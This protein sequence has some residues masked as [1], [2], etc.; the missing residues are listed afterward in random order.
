MYELDL[1]H[2]RVKIIIRLNIRRMIRKNIKKKK[3][4]MKIM[5]IFLW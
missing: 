4:K 2:S 1:L 5:K 3:K